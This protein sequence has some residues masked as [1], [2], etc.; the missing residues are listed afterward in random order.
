[1]ENTHLAGYEKK[2]FITAG[3]SILQ[4]FPN[5]TPSYCKRR[6]DINK[7]C[8]IFTYDF[9]TRKCTLFSRVT[10]KYPSFDSVIFSKV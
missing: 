10:S 9:K 4:N 8:R 6:C 3:G 1:M 7:T 2:L 5:R